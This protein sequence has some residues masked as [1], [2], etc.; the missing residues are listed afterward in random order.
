L[1]AADFMS[2]PLRIPS[3]LSLLVLTYLFALYVPVVHGKN[4]QGKI[5]KADSGQKIHKVVRLTS[6]GDNGEA[7]FSPDG[8][9]LI[10]Q[11]KKR[12]EHYNSQ[13]YIYDFE[14]KREKRLNFNN[15]DDTCSYFSPDMKWIIYA[16]TFDE[17][18]ESVKFRKYTP[19]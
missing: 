5:I 4:P 10:Y 2:K 7:Y 1:K 8:K 11:S 15:G 9:K 16:S 3:L 12:P 13:I 17:I 19:G 6:K 18:R 14:T